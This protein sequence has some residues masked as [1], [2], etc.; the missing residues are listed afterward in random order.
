MKRVPQRSLDYPGDG[1]YYQD[2]E[3]FTGVAFSLHKD[4]SL[5]SETE[6]KDGLKWGLERYWFAPDKLESEAHMLRGVVHGKERLWHRNGKPK[7]EGD[8]QFGIALRIKK[9]DE[10]GILVEDFELKETDSNYVLLQK[11]REI[12]KKRSGKN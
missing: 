2:D 6:Y 10:D 4:G 9:W 12:E 7:E 5:K 1:Y 11:F 3:P 8:Y